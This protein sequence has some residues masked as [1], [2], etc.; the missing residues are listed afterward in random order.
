M[1]DGGKAAAGLGLLICTFALGVLLALNGA[2]V[3]AAV[4][5]STVGEAAIG[6]FVLGLFMQLV[7][8]NN[9]RKT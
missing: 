5:S 7:G 1:T 3:F 2:A 6:W 4:V 9:V 8:L